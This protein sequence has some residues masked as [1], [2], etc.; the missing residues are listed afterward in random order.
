M[1]VGQNLVVYA[2]I[3]LIRGARVPNYERLCNPDRF[4]VIASSFP[5]KILQKMAGD[6]YYVD[7][8]TTTD[9]TTLSNCGE[10][11][12][13]H[14]H[15]EWTIDF[16]AKTLSGS[17]THTFES[18]NGAKTIDF[19]SSALKIERA[20]YTSFCDKLPGIVVQQA[21]S[22]GWKDLIVG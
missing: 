18:V 7:P 17:V 12:P 11:A 10:V 21:S 15:L 22:G 1:T 3:R 20:F 9:N 19:D 2:R 5:N 6:K 14:V 13:K 16:S 8:A 4:E